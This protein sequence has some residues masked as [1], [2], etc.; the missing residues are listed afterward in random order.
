MRALA[1]WVA[2]VAGAGL[3]RPAPGT[4]GSAAALLPGLLLLWASPWALAA[5]L[6]VAV[7]AGLWAIP[8]S[9]AKGDPG[10]VVID[11]LAGQ[12]VAL[13]ALAT[14]SLLGALLAFALFRIFDIFKPGPIGWAERL[15]GAVGVMADDL[16]GGLAA[17]ILLAAL[18]WAVPGLL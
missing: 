5:G 3:L 9:G 17:A 6:V 16:L 4:F 15:P 18:R 10:W 8:A 7:V 13:L 1:R 2:S 12:W 11:E 14:P